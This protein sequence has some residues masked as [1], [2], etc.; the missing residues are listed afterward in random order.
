VG[1]CIRSYKEKYGT[2]IKKSQGGSGMKAAHIC[3]NNVIDTLLPYFHS[4]I[5]ACEQ[6]QA[7]CDEY[8][9]GY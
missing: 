6:V 3:E 5:E 4:M 8:R 9:D 1:C 2:F 7:Y